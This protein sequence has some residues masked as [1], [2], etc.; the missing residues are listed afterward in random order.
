MLEHGLRK[1]C[2][3][4]D[5]NTSFTVEELVGMQLAHAKAQAEHYG[6][7]TVTGAVITAPPYWNQFERQAL[8]DAARLANL[9]V[10]TLINDETAVALNFAMTRTFTEPQRHIF[11][12]MGAGGTVATLVSFSNTTARV[13][14]MNQTIPLMEVTAVGYDPTLGGN[15]IDS[16][17]QLHFATEFQNKYQKRLSSNVVD[18]VRAMAKFLKEANR[19][20]QILSVN[21]ETFASVSDS[22]ISNI[23]GRKCHGRIG[24]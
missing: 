18:N 11:Y 22:N 14:F 23:I 6:K 20:K 10:F 24:L 8:L 19:V 5:R 1:T 21:S 9:R 17:L 2:A 7:E 4:Q 13:G 16:K 3:F 15:L 12:D